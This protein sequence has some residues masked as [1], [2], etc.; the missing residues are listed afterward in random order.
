MLQQKNKDYIPLF[1]HITIMVLLVL[2]CVA[3]Y[4]HLQMGWRFLSPVPFFLP[5]HFF[6]IYFEFLDFV[7][8]WNYWLCPFPIFFFSCNSQF[9]FVILFFFCSLV[10]VWNGTCLKYFI[11]SQQILLSFA[12]TF[13]ASCLLNEVYWAQYLQRTQ[14]YKY[15]TALRISKQIC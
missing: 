6:F 12:I 8:I 15:C 11:N 1:S 5:I 7:E 4:M 13:S 10:F 14:C 9:G 2:P 3:I